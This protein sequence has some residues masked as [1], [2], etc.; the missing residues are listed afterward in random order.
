MA[1]TTINDNEP[2][3]VAALPTLVGPSSVFVPLPDGTVREV[4]PGEKWPVEADPSEFIL[5]SNI[6][7]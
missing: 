1:K 4:K 6:W 3:P 7:S 5:P 2:T